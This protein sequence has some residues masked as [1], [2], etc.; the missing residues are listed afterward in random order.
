MIAHIIP[1]FDALNVIILLC[2]VHYALLGGSDSSSLYALGIGLIGI[3]A[4]SELLKSVSHPFLVDPVET[5]IL[6]GVAIVLLRMRLRVI[7][8]KHH[9]RPH[10]ERNKL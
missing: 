6:A 2:C 10:G 7:F 8:N 9:R 5:L 3:G 4:I 1:I